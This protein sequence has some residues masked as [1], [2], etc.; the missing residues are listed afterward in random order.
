MGKKVKSSRTRPSSFAPATKQTWGV[1]PN[2]KGTGGVPVEAEEMM[3]TEGGALVFSNS[4]NGTLTIYKVFP[5]SA[6]A[7][8]VAS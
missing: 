7:Y 4:V 6:Y 8:V 2:L 5:P 1:Y 3:V